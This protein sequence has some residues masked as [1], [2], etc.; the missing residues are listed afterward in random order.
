M[1]EFSQYQNSDKAP[2][3]IYELLE[4]IIKKNDGCK[5][6]HENSFTTEVSRCSLSGSSMSTISSLRGT[7][8]KYNVYRDKDCMKRF[9]NP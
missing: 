7:A 5:N 6:T 9:M 2:L 3:N 8:N 1:L 4:C